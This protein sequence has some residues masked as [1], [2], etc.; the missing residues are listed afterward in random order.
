MNRATPKRY[1][2]P[3]APRGSALH[4]GITADQVVDPADVIERLGEAVV[5]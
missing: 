3:A 1:A 2:A 4:A 5:A